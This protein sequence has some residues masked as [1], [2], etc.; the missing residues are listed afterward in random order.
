MENLESKSKEIL[1][2]ILKALSELDNPNEQIVVLYAAKNT[3]IDNHSNKIKEL[4]ELQDEH[5]KCI[6]ILK[7]QL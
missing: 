4:K 6:N 3:L 1:E 7:Q 2:I 5:I